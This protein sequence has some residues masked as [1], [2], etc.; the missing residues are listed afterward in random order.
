MY[1][2][3]RLKQKTLKLA[4]EEYSKNQSKDGNLKLYLKKIKFL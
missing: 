1:R 3:A 4:R 2:M